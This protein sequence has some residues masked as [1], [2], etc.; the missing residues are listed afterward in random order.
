MYQ[1]MY[2]FMY[3]CMYLCINFA[4]IAAAI[5]AKVCRKKNEYS[6]STLRAALTIGKVNLNFKMVLSDI[7]ISP[8]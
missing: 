1:R 4:K 2:L 7:L 5:K 8:L 3:L 6:D